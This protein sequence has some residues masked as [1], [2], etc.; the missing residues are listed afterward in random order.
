[1]IRQPAPVVLAL[2][3]AAFASGC[4]GE[5]PAPAAKSPTAVPS[6]TRG[7]PP[8]SPD[9]LAERASSAV[10]GISDEEAAFV[11]RGQSTVQE[12]TRNLSPLT[13]GMRYE[14]VVA[15]AGAGA[16]EVTIGAAPSQVQNCDG[17]AGTYRIESAPAELAIAVKGRPGASGAIAWQVNSE[18]R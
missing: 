7:T 12:G 2:A 11:E 17:K 5:G 1:M 14:V 9:L 4:T 13:K 18:P 16:V 8:A 3:L 10:S 15:C 6:A